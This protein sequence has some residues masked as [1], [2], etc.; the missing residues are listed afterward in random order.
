M[1]RRSVSKPPPMPSA[2]WVLTTS[3]YEQYIG[4][5]AA[6]MA[7]VLWL[8]AETFG[9][10]V[11]GLSPAQNLL[12]NFGWYLML[13]ALIW[14][15]PPLYD[16]VSERFFPHSAADPEQVIRN[17]EDPE[18]REALAQ[19]YAYY[20]GLPPD[21]LRRGAACLL[22]CIWLFEL[23]FIL[24]WVQGKGVERHLVWRPEWAEA[25]IAWF[26][27]NIDVAPYSPNDHGIFMWDSIFTNYT[28]EE[29]LHEP[30]ADAAFLLHFF[31]LLFTLPVIVCLTLVLWKI[32]YAMG[33]SALDMNRKISFGR[34]LWLGLANIILLF[35][36]VGA[37]WMNIFAID[38]LALPMLLGSKGW[39]NGTI[40]AVL[41]LCHLPIGLWML[42][43]WVVFWKRCFVN[44]IR[45]IKNV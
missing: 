33:A 24:A 17:T 23:F 8:A 38:E 15:I 18:A 43:G 7:A 13:A 35:I 37:A 42:F 25:V 44:L 45:R 30:I 11:R 3:T 4:R 5:Y 39:I 16:A 40:Y 22:F 31:R 1:P 12:A 21:R 28:A 6:C 36:G 34:M 9:F 26:R 14:F 32:L 29:L 2:V 41:L 10:R 20:G 19:Y 27:A